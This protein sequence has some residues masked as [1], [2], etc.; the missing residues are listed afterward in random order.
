MKIYIATPV[1]A[2]KEGTLEEKR[3]AA[4]KRICC[5]KYQL[6]KYFPD[7]EYHSSFDKEIAPIS[8]PVT[9]TEAEIMGECVT[10]VMNCDMVVQ[11]WESYESKGCVLERYTAAIYGKT[12]KEAFHFGIAKE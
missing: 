12:I 3:K 4:Y 5:M 9:K 1:N 6:H 2:R 7:A 10:L 8:K 11:D